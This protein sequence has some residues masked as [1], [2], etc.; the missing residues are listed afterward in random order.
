MNSLLSSCNRRIRNATLL[1]TV[2]SLFCMLSVTLIAT[3]SLSKH[4][5]SGVQ[6]VA[7]FQDSD[8]VED[9]PAVAPDEIPASIVAPK[10]VVRVIEPTGED[11]EPLGHLDNSDERSAIEFSKLGAGIESLMLPDDFETVA[12]KVHVTLQARFTL[13]GTTKTAVPFAA[14]TI[15]INDE[16]VDISGW[17]APIWVQK[18]TG[19]FEAFIDDAQGNPVVRIEREYITK[20]EQRHGFYLTETVENLTGLPIRTRLVTLGPIDMPKAKSTYAGDRRR[21]RY[22][23]LQAPE[24]QS[25]SLTVTV[26][27]K[28]KSRNKIFGKKIETQYGKAYPETLT[29]W[30]NED[31]L[32]GGLR[33][34]WFALVDRYF[35]VAIHPHLDNVDA[36]QA[37][38]DKLL[39]GI[40]MIDR[41]ALNPYESPMDGVQVLRLT[42]EL[43]EIPANSSVSNT[44]GVYAGPRN[45][46]LMNT[47][48]EIAALNMPAL[49]V[50]NLGGICAPCTFSWLTD[51]LI[52]VLRTFHSI[53]GDWA[54]SILLLVVLVRACLHPVT[55]W[56]QIRVQRFSVQM[57]AMA[58]KQKAIREKYK[59]D[60]KRQ[61]QE[62]GKLW[63][64][65]GI[66]PAGMLGCLPMFL[67]SPVWIA[68]YATLFFASELRHEPAFY[69]VFQNVFNWQFMNDLAA[70]DGAIPLPS[71]M[72]FSFPMW[73][74]VNSI[75]ILPMLLGVVFYLHQ[76]YLTPPTQATLT[77]EQE[78]QQKMM[79]VM[80]VFLFPVMMYAAPSGLALYFITNS[81]MGIIENKWIRAHMKKHGMLEI[82]NIRAEK[83][84]KGPGFIQRMN[85][86][87]EAQKQIREKGPAQINPASKHNRRGK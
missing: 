76:K 57:Q 41:I 70:P 66:S 84:S 40:T 47:E 34:S 16:Q 50:S 32:E 15:E 69:G 73:G 10:Y 42:G 79:K 72:H 74:N 54:V 87:A 35:V 33:L 62:M 85:E 1:V 39:R 5:H 17:E 31:V 22:G 20:P 18:S 12:G 4:Q 58:P 86:A 56:S 7:W 36:I 53:V 44:L 80:M 65:E 55:R 67:Q 61:Q 8:E 30:P 83:R 68:L 43:N 6:A 46:P 14:M 78:S 9:S 26:D 71:A 77:P 45:R 59:D 11:F 28:L 3:M 23:F 48:P 38:E 63:K 81:T 29:V 21:I 75:N 13:E 64:E 49:V 27:D 51:I 52:G 37:P 2:F 19:V 60:S 82:E 25:T 24:Q